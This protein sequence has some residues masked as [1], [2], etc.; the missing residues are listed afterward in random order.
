MEHAVKVISACLVLIGRS[1][2]LFVYYIRY[3]TS[4]IA[5]TPLFTTCCVSGWAM[6]DEALPGVVQG[7]L[8]VECVDSSGERMFK[9]VWSLLVSRDMAYSAYSRRVAK[10]DTQQNSRIGFTTT[11]LVGVRCGCCLSTAMIS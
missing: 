5:S 9:T 3:Y 8:E 11:L 6:K 7:C 1:Q 10:N 2:D 4:L